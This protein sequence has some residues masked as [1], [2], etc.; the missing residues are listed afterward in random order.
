MGLHP[1]QTLQVE[2]EM[3]AGNRE[4]TIAEHGQER[5][6]RIILL[7]VLLLVLTAV[8]IAWL[9]P[10]VYQWVRQRVIIPIFFRVWVWWQWLSHLKQH[11]VWNGVFLALLV[12]SLY[13]LASGLNI[14]TRQEGSILKGK[15]Q[16]PTQA[17]VSFWLEQIQVLHSGRGAPEFA[18]REFRRLANKLLGRQPDWQIDSAKEAMPE[19][20]N[21]PLFATQE[22]NKPRS[23]DEIEASIEY[24][25]KVTHQ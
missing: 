10:G 18:A 19:L 25:E 4:H 8:L 5:K 16:S 1:R 24:L 15:M 13:L 20:L 2:V 7:V 11:E 6:R 3:D 22:K 14:P 17:R 9:N 21:T 12:L 23:M